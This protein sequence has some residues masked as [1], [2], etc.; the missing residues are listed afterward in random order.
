MGLCSTDPL[1]CPATPSLTHPLHAQLPARGT[2]QIFPWFLN[3][4]GFFVPRTSSSLSTPLVH[5]LQ[6][7]QQRT[8]LFLPSLQQQVWDKQG[9]AHSQ[10]W[11][12]PQ[13]KFHC[14]L[15]SRVPG[16]THRQTGAAFQSP[17]TSADSGSPGCRGKP[18][19]KS[20]M[21]SKRSKTR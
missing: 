4:L 19:D 9:R 14:S 5:L 7:P 3:H 13:D 2:S 11:M 18:G 10:L 6:M 15:P 12:E 21:Q 1:P 20:H 8:G 16:L 17:A